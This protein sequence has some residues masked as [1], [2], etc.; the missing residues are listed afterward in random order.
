MALLTA[1]AVVVVTLKL[2]DLANSLMVRP[3]RA[4]LC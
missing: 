3:G 2:N 4:S 1:R